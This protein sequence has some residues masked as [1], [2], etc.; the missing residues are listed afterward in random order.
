MVQNVAQ[1][2]ASNRTA[3]TRGRDAIGQSNDGMP[4]LGRPYLIETIGMCFTLLPT[5]LPAWGEQLE[6][7][8][9]GV[10]ELGVQE[11][12]DQPRSFNAV[13]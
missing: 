6:M 11:G 5:H 12:G 10:S 7:P 4:Y 9:L 8:P 13:S 2:A 1:N 3:P